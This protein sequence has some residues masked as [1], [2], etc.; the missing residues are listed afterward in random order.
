MNEEPL[1]SEIKN[2]FYSYFDHPW[3][4]NIVEEYREK[5]PEIGIIRAFLSLQSENSE[6]EYHMVLTGIRALRDFIRII[7]SS[8]MPNV[9]FYLNIYEVGRIKNRELLLLKKCIVYTLPEN[10]KKLDFL[11]TEFEKSLM[12]KSL[13]N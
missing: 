5:P 10:I 4:I 7:K 2:L 1:F 13:L 12:R 6:I 11:T 3:L 8:V 9:N